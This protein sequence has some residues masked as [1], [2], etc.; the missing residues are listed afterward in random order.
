[1]TS[2]LHVGNLPA[3]VTDQQLSNK[4]ARFGVVEF[5]LVVKDDISGESRYFGLVEMDDSTSAEQAAKWLNFSSCEGQLMAVS[6]FQ[7]GKSAH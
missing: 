4:F 2:K 5:A 3:G 6:L 1:M 7:S